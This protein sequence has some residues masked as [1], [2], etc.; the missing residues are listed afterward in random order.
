MKKI[1]LSLIILTF[2]VSINSQGFATWYS[3]ESF[4]KYY[5]DLEIMVPYSLRFTRVLPN[6]TLS[7]STYDYTELSYVI[8]EKLVYTKDDSA[9]YTSDPDTQ[10]VISIGG[11][12]S[13]SITF[14]WAD[15]VPWAYEPGYGIG[16]ANITSK[17][18][19]FNKTLSYADA[20]WTT[21]DLG[22]TWGDW[23]YNIFYWDPITIERV[24]DAI[25]SMTSTFARQIYD[26]ITNILNDR[27]YIVAKNWPFGS[28]YLYNNNPLIYQNSINIL[29]MTDKYLITTTDGSIDKFPSSALTKN[30]FDIENVDYQIAITLE[31]VQNFVK[32][33]C[34]NNWFHW[35]IDS[36]AYPIQGFDYTIGALSNILPKIIQNHDS[37]TKIF[38]LCYANNNNLPNATF[39][40]NSGLVEVTIQIICNTLIEDTQDLLYGFNYVAK[41][42]NSIKLTTYGETIATVVGAELL[43]DV[44]SNA[45]VA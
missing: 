17:Y 21:V 10:T 27:Y 26:T 20:P 8:L 37:H 43:G 12:F 40:I 6:A 1:I 22:I 18:V 42:I 41:F 16:S 4:V 35:H 13:A 9:I 36:I 39:N 28:M 3:L 24:G 19:V 14:S 30:P 33:T 15:Q 11:T 25:N 2:L 5:D 23:E 31:C 34:L 29:K 45:L 7:N 44:Q 38:F 32:A